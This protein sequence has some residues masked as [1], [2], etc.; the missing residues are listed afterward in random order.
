VT[1]LYFQTGRIRIRMIL[2]VLACLLGF[3]LANIGAYWGFFDLT[4]EQ[5][6]NQTLLFSVML[7]VVAVLLSGFIWLYLRPV[8]AL[9]TRLREEG[10]GS[11]GED[12]A[13]RRAALRFPLTFAGLA[14]FASLVGVVAG[15]VLD[16]TMTGFPLPFA[17]TLGIAT[18]TEATAVCAFVYVVARNMMRPIIAHF[19]HEEVPSGVRVAIRSKVSF[20]II[21]LSLL[22]S[23][24]TALIFSG[25][26]TTIE[27]QSSNRSRIHLAEAVAHGASA[28]SPEALSQAA[29]AAR[30]GGGARILFSDTDSPT[31]APLPP[32]H[33]RAHVAVAGPPPRHGTRLTLLVLVVL[34]LGLSTFVGRQL[35]DN[36]SHDVR[37]VSNRLSVLAEAG[38]E[39]RQKIKPLLAEAPQFSDL[40]QLAD[41]VNAL[42]DRFVELTVTQFLA[43]E[44]TL[45]ADQVKTQFLA[46]VSHD[47]RSPLNSVLGFSELLLRLS[48]DDL[49][50]K[51][52]EQL[53]TI[54]RCGG[55]LLLLIN[56]VLD[57]AKIQAGRVSLNR[58]DSLPAELLSKALD[59]MQRRRAIPQGVQIETELQAGMQAVMVD[60]HRLIQ[61][62]SL[63]I[64][65]CVESMDQGRIVVQLRAQKIAV[66]GR[67]ERAQ[68]LRF[69]VATTSGGLVESEVKRLFAGFQRKPGQ[70]G[71]GL[72]L[73]L[74]KAFIEMHDGALN[75][76]SNPR[77]GTTFTAEIPILQQ[78]VLARLRPRKNPG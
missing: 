3:G 66:P 32:G 7:S 61:A 63:I 24:P 75:L 33:P 14:L 47:L 74:A 18:I 25:R 19:R 64:G 38:Q 16:V 17:V 2:V 40:R 77:I 35:G 78:K 55:E 67:V 36:L 53:T 46:N 57:T 23:I 59:E 4:P 45:E 70:R 34:L 11:P 5:L 69:R 58:E 62:M 37:L 52:K 76:H 10:L 39:D 13:A 72:G 12:E 6:F 9:L 42:L 28:L 50:D 71:L 51:Q 22:A 43:I 26:L 49:N 15:L 41:A 44:K 20:A 54:N 68:V 60:P 56:A 8:A 73:P 30:L 65:F 31:A 1:R 48:D 21:S 29:A 27:S